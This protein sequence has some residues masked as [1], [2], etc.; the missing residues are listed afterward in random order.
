MGRP[1]LPVGRR[2]LRRS[3]FPDD[4]LD[5]SV[6]AC[7]QPAGARGPPL[8]GV[9]PAHVRAAVA[10]VVG[11]QRPSGSDPGTVAWQDGVSGLPGLA[12]SRIGL[13]ASSSRPG[14][15]AAG[16]P[17][18]AARVRGRVGPPGPLRATAGFGAGANRGAAT[19]GLPG[20]GRAAGL[21]SALLITGVLQSGRNSDKLR[22]AVDHQ[23]RTLPV[24]AGQG[25]GRPIN[26]RMTIRNVDA[27]PN[28]LFCGISRGSGTPS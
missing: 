2:V 6:M 8:P 17:S 15:G 13:R 27:R 19:A 16:S 26:S 25:L 11:R 14:R 20:A 24:D 4:R 18:R 3:D 9:G 1:A 5:P 12:G 10:G 21:Q 28:S 7:H 23:K 22:G